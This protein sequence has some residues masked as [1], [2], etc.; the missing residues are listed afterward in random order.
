MMLYKAHR[1]ANPLN[2]NF[3]WAGEVGQKEKNAYF[4]GM[5]VG[6]FCTILSYITLFLVLSI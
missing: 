1:R 2:H 3:Y 6:I 4:A 5:K